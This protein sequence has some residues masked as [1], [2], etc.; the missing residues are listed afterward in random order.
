VGSEKF[1]EE[2][3][4]KTISNRQRWLLLYAAGVGIVFSGLLWGLTY[5]RVGMVALPFLV[6]GI[7]I[8]QLLFRSQDYPPVMTVTVLIYSGLAY[9]ALSLIRRSNHSK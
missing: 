5:T 2:V 7:D 8:S 9:G 3:R 1:P 4:V 6:P